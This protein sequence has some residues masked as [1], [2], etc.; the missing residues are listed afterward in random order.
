[1]Y[2]TH[3]QLVFDSEISVAVLGKGEEFI[4]VRLGKG[5]DDTS[6][7]AM[8]NGYSYAGVIGIKDGVPGVQCEP[9]PASMRVMVLAGLA[10]AGMIAEQLK[11]HQMSTDFCER[12]FALPDPRSEA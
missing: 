7:D 8:D 10:F 3:E 6:A 11:Q 4:L 5:L 12:L 1:M 9:D 2:D